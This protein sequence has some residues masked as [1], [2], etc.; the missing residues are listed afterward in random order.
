MFLAKLIAKLKA[1]GN[2][3]L[4]VK[5]ATKIGDIITDGIIAT[6]K[7]S[8]VEL[9]FVEIEL[10]NFRKETIDKYVKLYKDGSYKQYGFKSF[11]T[12]LLICDRNINTDS[13]GFDIIQYKFEE[14]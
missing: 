13:I 8:H 14:L 3:I 10:S 5:G 4:K 6:K 9:Y 1:D 7:D 12:V 2:E 11:P